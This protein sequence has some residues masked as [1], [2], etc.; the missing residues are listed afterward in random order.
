MINI[1]NNEIRNKV[2]ELTI[3]DFIS[4]SKWM[5]DTSI[6]ELDRYINIIMI[7]GMPE[8]EIYQLTLRDLQ[9]FTKSLNLEEDIK[10][11]P[12]IKIDKRVYR[13]FNVDDE[14]EFLAK[15]IAYIQNAIEKK[16][17]SMEWILDAISILYKDENLTFRE[18]YDDNHIKYKRDLFKDISAEYGVSWMIEI[19]NNI[20][21]KVDDINGEEN[22]EELG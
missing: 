9:T 15:D 5:N 10:K 17:N 1:R 22:T 14:F 3:T 13:A 12:T 16:S 8:S 18:H 19:V 20:I 2:S 21:E 11:P 7:C 4:M 6:S